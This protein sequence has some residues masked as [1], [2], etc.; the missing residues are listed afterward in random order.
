MIKLL[1]ISNLYPPYHIGG[2]ELGCMEVLEGLRRKGYDIKVLTST[3]RYN[4]SDVEYNVI[5]AL[6]A[7]FGWENQEGVS[8][9]ADP[10]SLEQNRT[11]LRSVLNK[12]SPHIV[13]IWNYHGLHPSLLFDLQCLNIPIVYYVSGYW[14]TERLYSTPD[15]AVRGIK[16]LWCNIFGPLGITRANTIDLQHSQFVSEFVKKRTI[17][18]GLSCEK[19]LVIPWGVDTNAFQF[20]EKPGKHMRLLYVGQVVPHKGII[21][22]LEAFHKMR[23]QE[24]LED[25]RLRIVGGTVLPNHERALRDVIKRYGLENYV[26]LEGECRKEQLPEIYAENDILIF[27]SIWEEPFSITVLEA[28]ASGLAV[29]ATN[30]GGTSEILVDN[31]NAQIFPKEDA[32]CCADKTI[33][34]IKNEFLF[35]SIVHE[36]RNCIEGRFLMRSMVDKIDQHLQDV[37]KRREREERK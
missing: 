23:Q 26:R 25:T 27:P 9:N 5:R 17:D 15:V 16:K 34:L 33:Q 22:A 12:F 29:V 36:A 31:V 21:T 2:Y 10:S 30:T 13:Y 35:E 24:G 18:A 14:L 8:I 3:Y 28:M 11:V 7:N 20:K 4:E 32:D 6:K 1:V 19:G 37:A